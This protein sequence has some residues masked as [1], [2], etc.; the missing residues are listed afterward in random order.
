MRLYRLWR[1]SP[2]ILVSL[3][4]SAEKEFNVAFQFGT[5]DEI[6]RKWAESIVK[7]IEA[8]VQGEICDL[9]Q[10][11]AP[12][13]LIEGFDMGAKEVVKILKGESAT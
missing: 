11:G 6:F 1:R 5:T 8:K 12:K 7:P 10:H 13:N 3:A 2:Q 4:K 9:I